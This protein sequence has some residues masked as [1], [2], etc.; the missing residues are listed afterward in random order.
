[1]LV[2]K[3]RLHYGDHRSKLFKL[4]IL[5]HK[6]FQSLKK[7]WLRAIFA[8]V[9]TLLNRYSYRNMHYTTLSTSYI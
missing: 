5:N 4:S 3:A 2:L 6:K 8:I 9:Q 7:P 1:M